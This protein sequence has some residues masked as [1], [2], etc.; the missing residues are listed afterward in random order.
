MLKRPP[1]IAER[2]FAMVAGAGY[3]SS[4]GI[5]VVPGLVNIDIGSDV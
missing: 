5:G 3:E 1:V 2:L 4:L